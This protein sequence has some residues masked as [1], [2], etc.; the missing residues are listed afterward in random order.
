MT[1][2]LTIKR[3]VGLSYELLIITSFRS[4]EENMKEVAELLKLLVR[5]VQQI[6][7]GATPTAEP[8]PPTQ[9][10]RPEL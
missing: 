4:S 6:R 10:D 8:D 9:T 5:E 7:S 2:S 3:T 1:A